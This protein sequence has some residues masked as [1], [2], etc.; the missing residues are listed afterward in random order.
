[1]G[2]GNSVYLQT[3]KAVYLPGEMV[4]GTIYLNIETPVESD[5]LF[6]KITGLEE[7]SWTEST[8]KKNRDEKK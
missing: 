5:G 4:T 2:T 8:N 6:L 7:T 3:D 1:M